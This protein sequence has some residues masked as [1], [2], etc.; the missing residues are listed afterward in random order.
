MN[1]DGSNQRRVTF[2]EVQDWDPAWSGDGTA[3]FLA[4]ENDEG[5][6]DIYKV[7]TDGSSL[8]KVLDS[9]SQ[10]SSAPYVDNANLARL[11]E[12]NSRKG[13]QNSP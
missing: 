11:L 13:A 12:L 1:A 6:Y 8:Q 4:S 10:V 7:N 9:G 5:F 3:L 2:N